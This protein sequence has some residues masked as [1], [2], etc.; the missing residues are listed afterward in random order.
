MIKDI[1]SVFGFACALYLGSSA[2]GFFFIHFVNGSDLSAEEELYET[3]LA[4]WVLTGVIA[5][6]LFIDRIM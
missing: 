1:L 4:A 6:G 5:I 3:L 2:L